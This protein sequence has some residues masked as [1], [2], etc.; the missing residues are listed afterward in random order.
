MSAHA[1]QL[2]DGGRVVGAKF[3]APLCHLD[4]RTGQQ[5]ARSEH[6]TNIT[7][8]LHRVTRIQRQHLRSQKGEVTFRYNEAERSLAHQKYL[9]V[10][11]IPY[12][13][14]LMVHILLNSSGILTQY[15]SCDG[16]L[17]PMFA[18]DGS[19]VGIMDIG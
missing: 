4:I 15:L 7:L 16:T 11:S 6:A 2:D 17:A 18:R 1:R 3:A 13:R 8:Y 19:L 14:C 5:L 10:I 9:C 12:S